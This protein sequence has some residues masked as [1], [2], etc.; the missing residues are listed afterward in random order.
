MPYVFYKPTTGGSVMAE[1]LDGLGPWFNPGTRPADWIGN[2]GSW[3]DAESD[4]GIP[5]D[6]AQAPFKSGG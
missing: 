1:Y 5:P 4:P 2:L 3:Q 6:I